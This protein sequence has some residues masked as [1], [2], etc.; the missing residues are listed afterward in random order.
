M[1]EPLTT[2]KG[3]DETKTLLEDA[4]F[5]FHGVD[6]LTMNGMGGVEIDVSITIPPDF[7]ERR[8]RR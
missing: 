7:R 6:H 4:G 3:L 5:I 2:N 8:A 1:T